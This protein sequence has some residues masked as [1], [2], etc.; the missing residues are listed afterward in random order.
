MTILS[1]PHWSASVAILMFVICMGLP[2]LFCH[3][4]IEAW[5]LW[6]GRFHGRQTSMTI[7][8]WPHWSKYLTDMDIPTSPQTSMTILSWPHWSNLSIS[9]SPLRHALPWLFCHG[10]IEAWLQRVRPLKAVYFH[11]YFVMAPL[12]LLCLVTCDCWPLNFHDYFVMAPLKRLQQIED[13]DS[14]PNFHDYFVMAPLK[15]E[16][17]LIT[18]A[19]RIDFHDYFVMAPLKRPVPWRLYRLVKLTS[20]TI[21]SWPHWSWDDESMYCMR[22]TNF[23]DYFVM[24]PLK[25]CSARPHHIWLVSLP[26]LFCHGPIEA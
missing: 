1:W 25:L 19:Q 12:K 16:R 15:L 11:D 23:H 2:W 10:P 3:G 24:A 4:P 7:L 21:L 26:W 17:A 22:Q 13:R 20:M 14:Q 5:Y 9:T 18:D 8:S 6:R